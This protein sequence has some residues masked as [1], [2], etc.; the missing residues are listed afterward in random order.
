MDFANT[1][2]KHKE[3][4][5]RQ[6][7]HDGI[8]TLAYL[9]L[10]F[11]PH[12]AEE[13][14][15]LL[16]G[17][18]FL[19]VKPWPSFDE[20]LISE[21]AEADAEYG[22]EILSNIRKNLQLKGIDKPSSVTLYQADTW[23]YGFVRSFKNGFATIKNPKDLAEHIAQEVPD[24]PKDDLLKLTAAVVKNMKLLP[25]IDR[26][27]E[28]ERALLEATAARLRDELSCPVA[29]GDSTSSTDQKAKNGLPGKPA[30]IIA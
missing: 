27:A 4:L 16:G 22:E 3:E 24:A 10:P 30:I 28:E 19:T 17:K 14:H 7:Y 1:L 6:V 15:E 12:V 13:M 5:S 26:T 8:E 9:L 25:L 23:K 18:G 21:R 2:T 29:I 20:S 11:T